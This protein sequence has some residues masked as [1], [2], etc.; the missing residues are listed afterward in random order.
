MSDTSPR[1][2]TTQRLVID[3]EGAR[4]IGPSEAAGLVRECVALALKRYD[5]ALWRALLELESPGPAADVSA[6]S[7]DADAEPLPAKIAR[8]VRRDHGKVGPRFRA[9]FDRLFQ[10]RRDG[11]PRKRDTRGT[12]ATTLALVGESDHSGQ[13]SLKNAVQAMK[14]AAHES[15]FGFDLRTRMIMREEASGG[16]YD[17]PWGASLLCDALGNTCRGLWAAEGVWRPIMEHLVAALTPELVAVQREMDQLLQDRDVLPVLKVRTRKRG[18]TGVSAAAVEPGDLFSRLA[19]T[20]DS[21]APAPAAPSSTTLRGISSVKT[22]SAV[23]AGGCP[24]R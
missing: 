22:S 18:A 14:A 5:G 2:S 9:E 7:R 4:D 10:D 6:A 21:A 20:Y 3:V 17:N 12:R 11:V 8:I 19:Q 23:P 13:V 1:P 15:G 24:A 16:E